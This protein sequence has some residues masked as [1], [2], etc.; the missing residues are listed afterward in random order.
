MENANITSEVIEA[1]EFPELARRY[2]VMAVPKTIV[3]NKV[4]FLGSV[5]EPTF[6]AQVLRAIGNGQDGA[7][8][9]PPSPS[10]LTPLQ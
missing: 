10:T 3:N 6:L 8:P 1:S 2:Q 7:P 9:P 5:P 4:E